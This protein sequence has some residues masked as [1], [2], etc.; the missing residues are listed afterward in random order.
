MC[1][2]EDSP[3]LETRRL[4][5]R[6]P[7]ARDASR[8]AELAADWD[9]VRMTGRMPHPYTAADAERFVATA[10]AQDPRRDNT[11]LLEAEREGVVGMLGFFHDGQ[12]F[13]EVGYWIGKPFWGRG[14][15]TEALDA[16][17]DWARR[18]W[19]K[20]AV[21]AGHFSDNP[22]SGRVLAKAG[23]LYTGEVKQKPSLARG[24]PATTRMMVWLA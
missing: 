7:E 16:A 12:P 10:N 11:F 15:A 20:R 4:L 22:A 18:K 19:K 13:P 5:L 2:I 23:F 9:V 24:E 14:F 3:R 17:M 8:I 6:A 1:V 21:M